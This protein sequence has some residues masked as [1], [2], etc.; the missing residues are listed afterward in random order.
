MD[1]DIWQHL[2]DEIRGLPD[3]QNEVET[4]LGTES[5]HHADD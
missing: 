4:S 5:D 3:L 2:T 1:D